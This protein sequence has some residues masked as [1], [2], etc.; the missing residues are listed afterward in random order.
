MAADLFFP[1]LE[2]LADDG[3]EVLSISGGEPL[4]YRELSRLSIGARAFG[5][6]VHMVTNGYAVSARQLEMLGP[7]LDLVAISIDGDEQVHD[8]L[9]RQRGS[10]RR[11]VDSLRKF[12]D[13][14][15]RVAVVSCVTRTS[16]PQV[17]ALHD[18]CVREQVPLLSLRPIVAVGRASQS[19]DNAGAGL[20]A[21]DLLRL[22]FVAQL[23]DG[24]SGTRVRADVAF[25][26]DIRRESALAYPFLSDLN[27]GSLAANV[28]PLVVRDD[29]LVLPY[30]YGVAD[31]FAL[32][33]ITSSPSALVEAREEWLPRIRTLISR[34]V[35]TLPEGDKICVD[36]FERV[37][38]CSR[39]KQLSASPPKL[40]PAHGKRTKS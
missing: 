27:R 23:L 12:R 20:A 36:W 37:L 26:A 30:V 19:A 25:C 14:G 24:A 2:R 18:L 39:D 32:G 38:R 8:D 33:H 34:T 40:A 22:K 15:V 10:F 28:N 29:G 5:F 9:R 35:K 17:P 13:R 21:S 6:K 7:L 3:Y 11:A 16:L 31:T 4:L 1:H